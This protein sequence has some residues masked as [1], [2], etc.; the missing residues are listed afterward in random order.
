MQLDDLKKTWQEEIV[1]TAVVINFDQLRAD[2]DKHDRAVKREMAIEL[3]GCVGII[4]VSVMYLLFKGDS[5]WLA[6]GGAVAMIGLCLFIGFKMLSSQR[7]NV[8][9]DWTL[10]A[11]LDTQIE[12]REKEI[13]LLNNSANWYLLPMYVVVI[14][15]SLGGRAEV[16]GSYIP[17]LELIF[18]WLFGTA[19]FIGIYYFN[20]RRVKTKV[21]PM[22]EKL[23]ELKEQLAGESA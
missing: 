21:Q 7:A 2:V 13:Q 23:R 22:L 15:S 9:D 11:R 12:A 19:F 5:N 4:S 17:D 1:M 3:F 16:T 18:N 8:V 6:Q 10:S 14:A 20:Q